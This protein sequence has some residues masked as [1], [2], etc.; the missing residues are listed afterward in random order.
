MGVFARG[1]LGC[2]FSCSLWCLRFLV[3][4]LGW[5]RVVRFG[6]AALLCRLLGAHMPRVGAF[7]VCVVLCAGWGGKVGRGNVVPPH[8][9]WWCC[10][11]R[12]VAWGEKGEGWG[13]H[14]V[15]N[16]PLSCD[17]LHGNG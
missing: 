15:V 2:A 5:V 1:W 7:V 9:A 3:L 4:A 17:R 13:A 11:P 6:L 16:T 8:A 14:G 10:P 12:C